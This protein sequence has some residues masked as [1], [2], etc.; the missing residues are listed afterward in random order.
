M[1]SVGATLLRGEGA[2]PLRVRFP[3]PDMVLPRLLR[4]PARYL[5]RLDIALPSRFGLKATMALLVAA[6]VY[7]IAV[8]GQIGNLV[9]GITASA[10]LKIEAIRITGQSE[11]P[12]LDV[13]E[14]L[15][16]PAHASIATFDVNA[17]RERVQ[18]IPWV[19]AVTIRKVYPDRLEVEIT[20][21]EP[22]AVWQRDGEVFL[23]DADGTVLSDYIAPR[24]RELPV[25]VGAGAEAQAVE[26]LGMIAQFPALHAQMR[27]ATLVSDRRW[28]LT[29]D[30]G[31]VIMLPEDD[32]V[33]ALIQLE[34]LDQA[35]GILSRDILSVDLRLPDRVVVALDEVV[36]ED[37]HDAVTNARA[38]ANR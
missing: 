21:R 26:I 4:R 25:L 30:N 28:N 19:D 1:R 20:E 13:L 36:F 29:L 5:S 17:A 6:G 22:F 10:G 12:E 24:F 8:G 3:L 34:T 7:G 18:Q 35:Q 16:I 15:A 31:I 9:G 11:T 27:G 32:P 33:P 37:V 2:E 23:I 38:E 14:R